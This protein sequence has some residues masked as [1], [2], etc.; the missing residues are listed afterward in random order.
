MILAKYQ[1]EKL[2]FK[3]MYPLCLISLAKGLRVMQPIP[4]PSGKRQGATASRSQL[5]TTSQNY[6]TEKPIAT[7]THSQS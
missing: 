5:H 2:Q 3:A 4:G 6:T 7:Y 1:N